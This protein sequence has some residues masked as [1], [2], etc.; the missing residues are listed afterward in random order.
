GKA[1]RS[2][3]I[4]RSWTAR[5]APAGRG[6]RDGGRRPARKSAR[7]AGPV[8]GFAALA[9]T[10]GDPGRTKRQVVARSVPGRAGFPVVVAPPGWGGKEGE[11]DRRMVQGGG[12]GGAGGEPRGQARGAAAGPTRDDSARGQRTGTHAEVALELRGPGADGAQNEVHGERIVPGPE[13]G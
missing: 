12:G 3:Q 4:A 1:G 8:T 7:T 6:R 2:W 9:L 10:R 5:R 13:A 11:A